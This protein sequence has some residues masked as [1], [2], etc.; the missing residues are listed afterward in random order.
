MEQVKFG[1][2]TGGL[3]VP[4]D[5][6][7]TLNQTRRGVSA[8]H[9]ELVESIAGQEGLLYPPLITVVG[10]TAM[11]SY[12]GFTRDAFGEERRLEELPTLKDPTAI[13]QLSQLGLLAEEAS[14]YW[15]LVIDGH[16]RVTACR[17]VSRRSQP[18]IQHLLACTAVVATSAE[19]IISR[20]LAANIHSRP[21]SD[22]EAHALAA[23]YSMAKTIDPS[24]TKTAFANK[25]GVS[26]GHLTDALSYAELPDSTKDMVAHGAS[27]LPFTLAVAIAKTRDLITFYHKNTLRDGEDCSIEEIVETEL[28]R[29]AAWYLQPKATA[30]KVQDRIKQEIAGLKQKMHKAGIIW[31]QT[32][33]QKMNSQP[34][35]LTLFAEEEIPRHLAAQRELEEL[36]SDYTTRRDTVHE[37]ASERIGAISA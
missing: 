36:L 5:E 14:T 29:F 35:E 21:S 4:L 3:W 25:H 28:L 23:A 26:A 7:T 2:A 12:L 9:G 37:I 17:E 10:E 32:E 13:N 11:Q 34:Q 30:K 20:Q 15:A 22:Q 27:G 6:V 18:N 24:L 8:V 19:D 1:P 33:F 16:S 31:D